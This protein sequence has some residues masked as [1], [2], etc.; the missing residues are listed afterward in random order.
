MSSTSVNTEPTYEQL[1]SLFRSYDVRYN[2]DKYKI[3]HVWP[4]NMFRKAGVLIPI[5]YKDNEWH[6]LLTVRTKHMPSHAGQVAFPGGMSEPSDPDAIATAFR[7]ANEEVGISQSD[8]KVVAVLPYHVVR[9]NSIVTPVLAVI[10]SD[11]EPVINPREVDL[12]FDLPLKRFLK[13]R[14]RTSELFNFE[15]LTVRIYYFTD[16]IDGKV[17]KTWGFTGSMCMHVAMVT[18][19]TVVQIDEELTGTE[20]T[21]EKCFQ[22]NVSR[23]LVDHFLSK[24][25][26]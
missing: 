16:I 17:V 3:E 24:A 20:Y 11:F 7:E 22:N 5:F 6:V 12:V 13:E 2:P 23:Q 25:N 15:N 19:Q 10:P 21:L 8:S 1:V 9:P 26:L 4:E 18:F 14:D